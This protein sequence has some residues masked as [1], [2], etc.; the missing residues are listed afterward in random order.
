MR[1]EKKKLLE[2]VMDNETYKIA[3]QILEKYAPDH[4]QKSSVSWNPFYRCLSASPVKE[5]DISESH[6]TNC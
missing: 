6:V 4:L 3:K 1:E 2:D 5:R